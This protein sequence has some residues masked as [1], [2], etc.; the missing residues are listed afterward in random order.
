M[1]L[2]LKG[3]SKNWLSTWITVQE[4]TTVILD[5]ILWVVQ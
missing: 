1:K 5:Y 3:T 2:Y 4:K